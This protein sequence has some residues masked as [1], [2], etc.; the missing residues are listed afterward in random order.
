MRLLLTFDRLEGDLAVLL[1]RPEEIL[2]IQWPAAAMPPEAREGDILEVRIEKSQSETDDA[3]AR[4]Q[5]LLDRL[6]GR[7]Q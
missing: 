7:P 3:A 6:Q 4:V 5:S 1:V 2:S